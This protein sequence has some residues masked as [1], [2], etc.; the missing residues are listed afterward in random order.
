[1]RFG[2]RKGQRVSTNDRGTLGLRERLPIQTQLADHC[3]D[4]AKLQVAVT[5]IGHDR[6]S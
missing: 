4:G 6:R 5:P 2:G 1:M 3:T